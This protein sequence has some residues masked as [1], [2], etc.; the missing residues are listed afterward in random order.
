M[1]KLVGK[2]IDKGKVSPIKSIKKISQM[3]EDYKKQIYNEGLKAIAAGEGTLF[4]RISE[5]IFYLLKYINKFFL[6][7]LL[8]IFSCNFNDGRWSRIKT[9]I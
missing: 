1:F 2:D 5:E 6:N 8:L 9:W 7:L 4:I 3:N